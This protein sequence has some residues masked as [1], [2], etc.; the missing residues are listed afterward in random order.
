MVSAGEL[1]KRVDALVAKCDS[2]SFPDKPNLVER[3]E[4][5][6]G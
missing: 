4:D 1:D 3:L 6:G 5:A 2:P